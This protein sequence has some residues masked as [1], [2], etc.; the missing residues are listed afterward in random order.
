MLKKEITQSAK[1]YITGFGPGDPELLTV[2]A[3]KAIEL[4][5]VIFFDDLIDH[6]FLSR[7]NAEKVY[8]GKRKGNHS[9]SQ[10][11]INQKLYLS[12][13]KGKTTVRLKGGDP[14][15]FGR[16]GEEYD[17]LIKR[18]IDV[19]VIPGITAAFGA[20]A[21][22]GLSLT[23]RNVAS[24]LA[25]CTGFPQSRS[26]VPEAD[27]LVFYMSA[28]NLKQ[29]ASRIIQQGRNRGTPVALIR[30]A[31]LTSQETIYSNLQEI[32]DGKVALASPMVA[33]IGNIVTK[34]DEFHYFKS[35][36]EGNNFKE[37]NLSIET[38]V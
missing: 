4:A 27:T 14:L 9:Y 15:I 3:V 31:T 34:P 25:F 29:T 38:N 8:V 13:I 18:M 17:Y 30:N 7:F 23:K 20:A 36:E 6:K 28:F 22:L 16:G 33:I 32:V 12:A 37:K 1:V 21:S 35:M 10:H 5:D 24:S 26:K 11:E 19:E 2:K